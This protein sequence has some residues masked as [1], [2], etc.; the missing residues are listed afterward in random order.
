MVMHVDEDS[1]KGDS[2]SNYVDII[3][4]N[5]FVHC[6]RQSRFGSVKSWAPTSG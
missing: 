6:E 1:S 2:V 5:A 3:A 4:E